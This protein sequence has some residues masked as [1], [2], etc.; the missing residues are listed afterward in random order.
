VKLNRTGN[1]L[2]RETRNKDNEN[3][4]AIEDGFKDVGND[5]SRID[6]RVDNFVEEV[7]NEA[8][9]KV[10]DNAKLN[11]KEPVDNFS[12]LPTIAE[13]GDTRMVRYIDENKNVSGKVY[14]YDGENWLEIQ[15]IDAGPVNELDSRLTTQLAQTSDNVSD[16]GVYARV[17]GVVADGVTN[18]ASAFLEVLQQAN[19]RPI[20]LPDGI[21]KINEK[22]TYDG[23]VNI[24]PTN[25]VF[26]FSDG[27]SFEFSKELTPLPSLS[28]NIKK[29]TSTF[30]FLETHYLEEGD[31]FILFNPNDYSWSN[32]RDYYRDGCM[33]KVDRV[34]S[35]TEVKV[36]GVSPDSYNAVDMS[37]LKLNGEGVNLNS[38]QIV[39]NP[40]ASLQV[41]IDGH[42]G[43]DLKDSKVKGGKNTGIEILRSYDL[44]IN[45]VHSELFEG[46]AYPIIISNSQKAIVS[47]VSLYS[48][49]HSVGLGGRSGVGCV[50]TRDILITDSHLD[51]RSG[52]GI[53]ASDIHG[54][55]ENIIYSNCI[56]NTGANIAGK[57]VKY[58]NCTIYGRDIDSFLDGNCVFGSEVVGGVFELDSCRFVTEGNGLSFG[59]VHLTVTNIEE[60]LLLKINDCTVQNG[61]EFSN[62]RVVGISHGS[63]N[64]NTNRVDIEIDGLRATNE[65]Q[66]FLTFISPSDISEVSS[67]VIDN[68]Y[69]PGEARFVTAR[70]SANLSMPMRLQSQSGS[71]PII[72]DVDTSTTNGEM[73]RFKYIYPRTPN[74]VVSVGS[75]QTRLINGNRAILSGIYRIRQTDIQPFITTGDNENWTTSFETNLMWSVGIKEI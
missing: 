69:A 27:G 42:V 28:N 59:I 41:L 38:L 22:I 36:F 34:V 15:Q 71:Q 60:D 18:N 47:E 8:L 45:K 70:N 10:V 13:E 53:G 68:V 3:W 23:K 66:S 65:I 74:A 44:K 9:G 11:W 37:V 25:T 30:K 5:I 64:N 33:F 55:C 21:I 46:D 39:P 12:D 32:Y 19:G 31:V 35:G 58:I 14:R 43:V 56:I 48:S 72:A 51:N 17:Y 4:A 7:S 16:L 20:I 67:C 24:A 40:N 61:K 49:R 57:N 26:D 73:K 1:P 75:E 29:G 63:E 54:N 50:P 2:D 62:L 52:D 6:S